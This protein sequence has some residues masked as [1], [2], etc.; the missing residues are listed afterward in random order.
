MTTATVTLGEAERLFEEKVQ[1][2]R[3]EM[4]HAERAAQEATGQKDKALQEV[5]TLH[6][7]KERLIDEL[8]QAKAD[9][10]RILDNLA[11][12][13]KNVEASLTKREEEA[14]VVILK[15]EALQAE[16]KAR[17]ADAIQLRA[18]VVGIKE[19]IQAELTEKLNDL[20]AF[21]QKTQQALAA[22]PEA[23]KQ[24]PE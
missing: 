4:G 19:T 8:N 15:A 7:E 11:E 21:V 24:L 14:M 23:L 22:I 10:Q 6:Q 17:E 9:K 18:Q 5:T 13:R 1:R 12:H 20:T 3:T 2:L 16:V